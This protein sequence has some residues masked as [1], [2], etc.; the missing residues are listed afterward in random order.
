MDPKLIRATRVHPWLNNRIA[1]D[2]CGEILTLAPSTSRAC[3]CGATEA[4]CDEGGDLR[5]LDDRV[6]PEWDLWEDGGEM[7][8]VGRA[9]VAAAIRRAERSGRPIEAALAFRTDG[10]TRA[11]YV[12]DY[13][14]L[15]PVVVACADAERETEG[16][17]EAAHVDAVLAFGRANLGRRILVHCGQGIGRAPAGALAILADRMGAGKEAEAVTELLRLRPCA[18]INRRFVEFA[19]VALGRGRALHDAVDRHALLRARWIGPR[20]DFGWH[21]VPTVLLP[22]GGEEDL[23]RWEPPALGR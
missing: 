9:G 2:A 10:E 15:D 8:V 7:T 21:R 22:D 19:D 20:C 23:S 17:P 5:P 6:M 12:P 4:S 13:L 1:C 16:A 11:G 14:G 3:A 18:V